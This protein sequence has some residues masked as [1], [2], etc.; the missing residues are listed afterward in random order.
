MYSN[1]DR[2]ALAVEFLRA[3]V[4]QRTSGRAI[5]HRVWYHAP[6]GDLTNDYLA[7]YNTFLARL[8]EFSPDVVAFS[9]YVWN[10]AEFARMSEMVRRFLPRC[11]IVWGGAQT[12]SRR[13]AARL[14]ER[15]S[16]LD[17]VVRG[18]AEDS[19]P[20]LLL[21]LA[22][23]GDIAA[24][25]GVTHRT[26][27]GVRH[28]RD[29]DPVALSTIPLVFTPE[30]FPLEPVLRRARKPALAY[31]TGRGCRQRCRFCLYGVPSL[32]AFAMDRV[33][34]ELAYLLRGRVP[35]LRICDAHFGISRT[36]S[37]ELFEIIA[38]HNRGTRIDIYPDTRHVDPEYVQAMNRAGCRVVSLG[39]QSSDPETLATSGRRFDEQSFARAARLIRRHHNFR[40]AAD[41]I[42]GLPGDTYERVKD[43]VRFAY[44]SGIETVECLSPPVRMP[45]VAE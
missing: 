4:R 24:V 15:F 3:T 5:D 29:A 37:M 2:F 42:I 14:L 21:A 45:C 34:Q 43:S 25:S 11:T 27:C 23:Q 31:E 13:M 16:W 44:R 26:S 28:A 32:R 38:M 17:I 35:F 41:V 39:I 22:S 40:L 1:D 30:T 8:F 9:V 36:R 10:Q 18:E 33:E 12:A 19:Y 7:Q 6:Y 20:Q